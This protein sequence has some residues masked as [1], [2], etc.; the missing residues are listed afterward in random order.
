MS[1]LAAIVPLMSEKEMFLDESGDH[2]WFLIDPEYPVCVLSG[3]IVDRQCAEG[4]LGEH[5]ILSG[6]KR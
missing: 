4:D 2:N 1:Q 5:R 3:V 6:S